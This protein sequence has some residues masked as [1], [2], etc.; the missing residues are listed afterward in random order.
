MYRQEE[1]VLRAF[2]RWSPQYEAFSAAQSEAA[3]C[4]IRSLRALLSTVPASR[5]GF[6]AWLDH[7]GSEMVSGG[8]PEPEDDVPTILRTVRAFIAGGANV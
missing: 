5:A 7:L 2:G 3:N 1:G 6:L 4:E 8:L